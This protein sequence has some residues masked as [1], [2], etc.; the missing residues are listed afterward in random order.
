MAVAWRIIFV[1]R[2]SATPKIQTAQLPKKTKNPQKNIETLKAD[3][4]TL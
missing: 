1:N 4:A 3:Y 2:N